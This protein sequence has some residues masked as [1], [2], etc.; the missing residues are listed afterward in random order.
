MT[1]QSP[2]ERLH[3]R[4]PDDVLPLL[5]LDVDLLQTQSVE[6]DDAIDTGVVWTAHPLKVGATGAV[7]HPMKNVE[8][9]SLEKRRRDVGERLQ[10]FG[11]NG[12]TQ[13]GQGAS[14]RSSGLAVAAAGKSNACTA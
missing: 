9:D 2:I 14:S 1:G 6:G 13:L 3:L 5:G 4:P 11:A 12:V 8:D 10:Q 7:S